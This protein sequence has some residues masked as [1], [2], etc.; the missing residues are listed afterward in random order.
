MIN[1]EDSSSIATMTMLLTSLHRAAAV[2]KNVIA[3]LP[4]STSLPFNPATFHQIPRSTA[5][6]NLDEEALSQMLVD[7]KLELDFVRLINNDDLG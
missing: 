2:P 5:N 3:I 4:P 7:Y 1:V 6:M